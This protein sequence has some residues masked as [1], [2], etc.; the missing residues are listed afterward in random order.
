MVVA[1][2]PEVVAVWPEAII[3]VAEMINAVEA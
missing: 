1:D 3:T 2:A